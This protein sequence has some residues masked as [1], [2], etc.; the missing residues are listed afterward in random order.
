M[1]PITLLHLMSLTSTT[2]CHGVSQGNNYLD[3]R[4]RFIPSISVGDKDSPHFFVI[5]FGVE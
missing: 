4:T 5:V 1:G 2:K 3:R